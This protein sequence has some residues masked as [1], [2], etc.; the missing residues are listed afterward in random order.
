MV[1][2]TITSIDTPIPLYVSI[3][4]NDL[5]TTNGN[6]DDPF[7]TIEYALTRIS[8]E[9]TIY[10]REGSYE[11][12]EVNIN[13]S[14]LIS[15][16]D[17]ENVTLDGSRQLNEL[18]DLSAN[19]DWQPYIHRTFDNS[20][21]FIQKNIYKIKLK[22]NI[23]IWQLFYNRY[24]VINARWPSAQWKDDSVYNQE[25]NWAHGYR[26]FNDVVGTSYEYHNGELIDI[27]NNYNNLYRFVKNLSTINSSS[28]DISGS[29]INLNVG[30]F[31]SYTKIINN[32]DLD[33][34]NNLI[35]LYYEPVP[36]W[37]EK[38]HNY[39]LENKLAYL[40]S[41]NEWFFDNSTKYLYLWLE[42]DDTPNLTNI[43]AKV[44]TYILN[45]TTD[46]VDIV[47][48]N[49]F[50]TTLRAKNADNLTI[51]NCNFLYPNCYSHMLN[52]TNYDSLNLDETYNSET[53][54]SNSDHCVIR[55]CVFKYTD[56]SVLN[57]T[58]DNNQ[59]FNSYF[60]YI[61]KT[62]VNLSE[63]M[64]TLIINGN[65]NIIRNNT[66]HKTGASSTINPGDSA[67]IEYNNLYDSGYLQSD[68]AMIHCMVNQQPNVKIRF[69]WVHDTLKYGIRF[70]GNGDGHSGYIHHNIGWNCTGGIMI[71]GGILDSSGNSVGGHFVYNN[72][73]FNSIEKNDIMVINY[74]AGNNINY[75][76]IIV[77]NLAQVISG[78]RSIEE[79][80]APRIY[81]AYNF[82]PSNVEE[83]LIDPSNLDFRPIDSS[84]IVDAG[85]N[86]L[87]A[88]DLSNVIFNPSDNDS[89]TDYIGA[90][91]YDKFWSAGI[92]WNNSNLP[93]EVYVNKYRLIFYPEILEPEPQSILNS[94]TVTIQLNVGWNMISIPLIV[95][96][97]A[98]I[99][100][101]TTQPIYTYENQYKNVNNILVCGLGYWIL[102]DNKSTVTISGNSLE[103]I[104]ISLNSGWNMIGTLS[105]NSVIIDTGSIL[106][107]NTSIFYWD[108]EQYNEGN[109]SNIIPGYAYWLLS[110]SVG[111]IKLRVI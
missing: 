93:D 11:F 100:S 14:L 44:Q 38:Y 30:S 104:D 61:D 20:N 48:L 102:V 22:E 45:I 83:Y 101:L 88:K 76:S 37:K 29:L 75:G 62:V 51:H 86:S 79:E 21:N 81:N 80:L 32:Y 33:D 17:S 39:Y 105:R 60:S 40:N 110:N 54:I 74:Q 98:S 13:K 69:N 25:K 56:G 4:G 94:S 89:L 35:K 52:R 78:H 109:S 111:T 71:K 49:L 57:I 66:I 64:T 19:S 7:K 107:I 58:G 87:P 15:G 26:K 18:I 92:D 47:N 41:E 16:Y 5:E 82:T 84:L 2:T 73:I 27:S 65:N 70:D 85:T 24:E 97:Y 91:E 12:D 106:S 63:V 34:G 53:K 59:I 3:L 103:E 108:N 68:G 31:K 77:N 10:I 23:E 50:S 96:D 46:N 95:D 1:N 9:N 99:T 28:F 36:L 72:T 67:I 90:V 6:I 8:N 42:N 55:N 43:R